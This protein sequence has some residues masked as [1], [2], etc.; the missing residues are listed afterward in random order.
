MAQHER[1]WCLF[2][3]LLVP[4]LHAAFA[5]AH[6][7]GPTLTISKDLQCMSWNRSGHMYS[8]TNLHFDVS[9]GG[10]VFLNEYSVI[11]EETL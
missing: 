5:L 10:E 4:P 9:R 1:T 8:I 2:D 7:Y 3:D 6:V 11:V